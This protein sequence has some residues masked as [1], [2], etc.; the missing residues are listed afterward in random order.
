M[1]NVSLRTFISQTPEQQREAWYDWFCRTSTLPYKTT[2]MTQRLRGF[3]KAAGDKIDLD[4][5]YVWFKNNCPMV[6]RLY[7]DF[8]IAKLDNNNVVYNVVPATGFQRN[9]GHAELWMKVNGT[10]TNVIGEG[11]NFRDVKEFIKTN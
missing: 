1:S 4:T 2:V 10:F 5:H 9:F 8:R 7:D 3:L 6:G 11:K